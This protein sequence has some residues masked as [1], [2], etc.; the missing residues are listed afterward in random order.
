MKVLR[1]PLGRPIDRHYFKIEVIDQRCEQKITQFMEQ[2]CG[3]F[4][5]PIP[6]S[7]I[8]KMIL[9]DAHLELHADLPEGVDGYT[10]YFTDRNP[11]VKISQRLSASRLENRFRFTLC[12]EYG[13]VWI[14]APLWRKSKEEPTG[15]G[16]P[17]WTCYR[18]T[19][20][21]AQEKDWMEWQADQI[22]GGLLMARS[23]VMLWAD[24]LAMREGRNPPLPA[25]SDL[26]R[27]V[28]ER[29]KKR[30]RVSEQAARMRL[31]R[32]GLLTRRSI[33]S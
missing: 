19:I 27:A 14:H 6:T 26:A 1:D 33:R 13:H 25:D 5:L 2:D 18:A 28:I 10:D 4:R 17:C 21:S 20:G 8:I 24:E 29:L 22:G 11:I 23:Y 31:L 15:A 32:L 16:S 12:H 7:A 30:C 3:G 9:A